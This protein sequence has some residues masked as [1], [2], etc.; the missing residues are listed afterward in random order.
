M[1]MS[2][3]IY[4]EKREIYYLFLKAK[5]WALF[6]ITFDGSET[7]TYN[8]HYS[9]VNI[10]RYLFLRH[11]FSQVRSFKTEFLENLFEKH[12]WISKTYFVDLLLFF[13][14][15]RNQYQ[16]LSRSV[17]NSKVSRVYLFVEKSNPTVPHEINCVK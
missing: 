2:L 10:Y 12:R 17:S 7:E 5:R 9:I 6:W 8:F 11:V 1:K 15:I 14:C 13:S 4:T 16:K 3:E